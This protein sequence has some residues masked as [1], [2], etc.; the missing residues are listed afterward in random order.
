MGPVCFDTVRGSH[1]LLGKDLLDA[2]ESNSQFT[3]VIKQ[4]SSREAGSAGM[5]VRG[6][7]LWQFTDGIN[8]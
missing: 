2:V 4:R 3:S 8:C 1:R 5:A 7:L 6:D